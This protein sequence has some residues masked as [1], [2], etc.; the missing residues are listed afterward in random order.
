MRTRRSARASTDGEGLKVAQE[1]AHEVE[2]TL[3]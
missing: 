3:G 2:E 1:V